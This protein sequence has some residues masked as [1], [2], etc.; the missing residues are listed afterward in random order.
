MKHLSLVVILVVILI[1]LPAPAQAQLFVEEI[2]ADAPYCPDVTKYYLTAVNAIP[3][4]LTFQTGGPYQVSVHRPWF[5]NPFISSV[6][7]NDQRVP[8]WPD[9][10]IAYPGD[11]VENVNMWQGH[12]INV[13]QIAPAP[14]PIPSP[15]PVTP[16]DDCYLITS[17]EGEGE[18]ELTEPSTLSVFG[19]E[20]WIVQGPVTGPVQTGFVYPAGLYG[21]DVTLDEGSGGIQLVVCPDVPTP[22]PAPAAGCPDGGMDGSYPYYLVASFTD[23]LFPAFASDWLANGLRTTIFLPAGQLTRSTKIIALG[24]EPNDSWRGIY[25]TLAGASSS[26]ANFSVHPGGDFNFS[27]ES[28]DGKY[29]SSFDIITAS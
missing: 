29:L 11:V 8:L 26:L 2:G 12:E 7:I 5:A 25:F 27:Y 17:G 14:T 20:M 10:V 19:G 24:V 13:C 3:N 6:W 22:T 23:R 1:S 4:H 28:N 16:P 9:Y 21:V 15:T 18:F